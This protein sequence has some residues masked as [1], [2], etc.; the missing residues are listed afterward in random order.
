MVFRIMDVLYM[1]I[2]EKYILQDLQLLLNHRSICCQQSLVPQFFLQPFEAQ[3]SPGHTGLCFLS[4]K[5][6]K[7]EVSLNSSFKGW[8]AFQSGSCFR[9]AWVVFHQNIVRRPPLPYLTLNICSHF[10][11]QVLFIQTG[12][13]NVVYLVRLWIRYVF[14]I[15]YWLRYVVRNLTLIWR[16]GKPVL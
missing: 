2:S 3:L 16:L 1:T 12:W 9:R 8:R 4:I 7:I 5:N 14:C 13:R 11:K 6:N 15:R 10:E